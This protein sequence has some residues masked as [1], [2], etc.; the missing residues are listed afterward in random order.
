MELKIGPG[1][2]SPRGATWDGT[3]VNF[4]LF[5]AHATRVELCL[6]D[7][8]KG[9]EV[10]RIALPEYTDQ[11]W[12]GHIT[13]IQPGQLYGYRV[14][15]PYEPAEGHRFNPNKLLLDPYAKL[16][17]GA[18]EWNDAL[19]GYKIGVKKDADL[20]LDKRDSAPFMPK[21]VVAGE[22][23]QSDI[24]RPCLP[25]NETV[26][27]EAHVKGLTARRS[28]IPEAIRGTFLG[29]AEPQIIEHLSRLGVTAIELLP[30]QA[31]VNDRILVDQGLSNYW[32]YNSIGFFAPASR[33]LTEGGGIEQ[34]RTMVD[35]YHR[36][37]I[38]VLLDVVYNHTAEGNEFG[39]TLSFRGIDNLSYYKLDEEKRHYYDT[40][41]CG[42]TLDTTHPRVLQLV[43]DSL[44]YWV[45]VGGVDGFRFDL[46]SALARD[47]DRFDPNSSFLDAISQD[48]VLSR[49]KLIAEPWD[50][51]ENG[52]QVGGFPPG[53][54]EWNDRWRD[55][56]RDYWRG[57][58]GSLPGLG[59]RVLGSA[60]VYDREGRRPW[61]SVN[62]ITAHDGFT[63]ADLVSYNEKHN[64]ANKEDN[65]DGHDD[66]RSWNCGVEGPTDD[67]EI[68]DIRDRLRR[69]ELA[70]LM[71]SQGTPMLNMGDEL[72]RTQGG[73]NNAFCQD[74]DISWMQW[75]EHSAR[76]ANLYGFLAGLAQLR[77]DYPLLRGTRFL[78][79]E[80]VAPGIENATWYKP[81][82]EE[83]RPEH[84]EDPVAK[85]V[86]LALADAETLLLQLYNS[87]AEEISFTLPEIEGGN[88]WRVLCDSATGEIRPDRP[89]VG[90]AVMIPGRAVL[91]LE[92]VAP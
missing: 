65:R 17:A 42:N 67:P 3:G 64:A 55:D 57:E 22:L 68:L 80:P 47:R 86:G 5:S 11:I 50:L 81:D 43:M 13:G 10:A 61:T 36:A 62:F 75:G 21:C 25:W 89:L 90:G 69:A 85:C 23:P 20:V 33:Y 88:R 27:Y 84:W 38:E 77:K 56:I 72:G 60:D 83:K 51:G 79:G 87:D 91:L 14:H 37:G 15:G 29:L 63:L 6:F 52:Y 24:E 44:R 19:F 76:D 78:H 40:T 49:A 30:V 45:E 4:A 71:F 53:W 41:G 48:P 82:G 92:R 9:N 32:G 74:N 39:P 8:P 35:A 73:N 7:G 12:H 54:A 1:A 2:P 28:D 34:F 59:A 70:S 66:N 18:L 31:F 16:Y 58:M 26:I 46:A